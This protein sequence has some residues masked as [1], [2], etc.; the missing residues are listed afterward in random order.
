[1]VEGNEVSVVKV[2]VFEDEDRLEAELGM[3]RVEVSEL[4][5]DLPRDQRSS[6]KKVGK[7]LQ[8]GK[9]EERS[10]PREEKK[11]QI[12]KSAGRIPGKTRMGRKQTRD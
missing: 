2:E 4:V 9:E 5:P 1:V 8:K 11:Q 10:S 7:F 6:K 3:T 12:T